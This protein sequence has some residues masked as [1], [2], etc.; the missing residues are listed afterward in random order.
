MAARSVNTGPDGLLC[1]CLQEQPFTDVEMPGQHS[2][3]EDPSPD[4]VVLLVGIGAD[5]PVVSSC[6]ESRVLKHFLKR[7]PQQ[8]LH[9]RPP[10]AAMCA[11]LCRDV[12][13]T[14]LP[15]RCSVVAACLRIRQ[16]ASTV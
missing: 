9:C 12:D 11:I 1:A 13:A 4:G 16:E 5:V 7:R 2:T 15:W 6:T 10:C 3:G 14:T 8:A